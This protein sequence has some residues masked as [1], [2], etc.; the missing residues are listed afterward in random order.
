[1]TTLHAFEFQLSR[2]L[3]DAEIA[4]LV[5]MLVVRFGEGVLKGA[6]DERN[7]ETRDGR[8]F[9][10]IRMS[11]E[12]TDVFVNTIAPSGPLVPV[13]AGTLAVAANVAIAW[14]VSWDYVDVLGPWGL[15]LAAFVGYVGFSIPLLSIRDAV[16]QCRLLRADRFARDLDARLGSPTRVAIGTGSSVGVPALGDRVETYRK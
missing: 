8:W 4:I 6:Q 10:S 1:M 12:R 2:R 9:V 16:S 14:A 15:I 11:A 7:W 3:S 13:L 5:E